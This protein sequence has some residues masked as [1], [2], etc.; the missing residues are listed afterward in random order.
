MSLVLLSNRILVSA[1]TQQRHNKGSYLHLRYEPFGGSDGARTF[2]IDTMKGY[3][4]SRRFSIPCLGV[5]H[6]TQ[7]SPVGVTTNLSA[8][9]L[10]ISGQK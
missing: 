1:H 2:M 4:N 8:E 6:C 5:V 9:Y 3:T 10:K 7:T